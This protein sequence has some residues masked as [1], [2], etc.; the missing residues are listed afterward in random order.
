MSICIDIGKVLSSRQEQTGSIINVTGAKNALEHLHKKYKLFIISYAS[1]NKIMRYAQ[2]TS[3]ELGRDLFE[4][5]YFV[6][7]RDFKADV[8]YHLNCN[9]IIDDREGVLEDVKTKNPDTITILYQEFLKQKKGN[10]KNIYW[11]TIGTT[12]CG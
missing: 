9:V 5:Q 2:Y 7:D 10:I 12:C 8:A 11:R 6:T 1:K 3:E 4:A